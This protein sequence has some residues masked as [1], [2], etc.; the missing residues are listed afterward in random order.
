MKILKK[1][2]VAVV[3]MLSVGSAGAVTALPIQSGSVSLLDTDNASAVSSYLT[4]LYGDAVP[5]SVDSTK[6][7]RFT[8]DLLGEGTYHELGSGNNATS[9]M[10]N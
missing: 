1:V 6:E 9:I 2:I 4:V 10:F 8:V 3:M 5:A 7:K